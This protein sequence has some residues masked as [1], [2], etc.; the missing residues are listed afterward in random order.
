MTGPPPVAGIELTV[1]LPV[2]NEPGIEAVVREVAAL[3]DELAP[4]AG[5]V[6]VVDDA[7]TDGTGAT[8]D[9]LARELPTVRV[10][11]QDP[12]QGHG[13]AV[14]RGFDEASGRWIGHLDTDDQIP[15]A[16]LGRL[17]AERGSAPLV[18]GRRVRRHDPRH[19]LVL[20][21][22][23]RALVSAL[24]RRRIP[25]ANVPCKLVRH[26]LWAEVRPLLPDDTFAPAVALA[27]VAARWD[28]PIR[29]VDVEHR[30]RRQG[31]STLRPIRLTRAVLTATGQTLRAVAGARRRSPRTADDASVSGQAS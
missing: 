15:T 8:V 21:R 23:V 16:E 28:R 19:R 11:R 2:Y 18:L 26:D 12:N 27:I 6:L 4:G 22:F 29:T 7:S 24:A 13:P 14:L 31:E 25:D 9:A 30:A 10:L 1:V 3:V 17:W 5:E 20:T